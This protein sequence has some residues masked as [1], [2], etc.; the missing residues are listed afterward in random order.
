MVRIQ[1]LREELLFTE[2]EEKEFG[3]VYTPQGDVAFAPKQHEELDGNEARKLTQ[4][5]MID[6]KH[7]REFEIG[8]T[9]EDII[10]DELKKLDKEEK[11]PSDY[12]SLYEKFV[13]KK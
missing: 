9:I 13:D 10:V 8:D 2:K 6:N 3:I 7:E 1:K 11:F 4:A 12:I 5:M